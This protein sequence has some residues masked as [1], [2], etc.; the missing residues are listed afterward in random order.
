MRFLW[1]GLLWVSLGAGWAGAKE[2]IERIVIPP[3]AGEALWATAEDL[4]EVVGLR[5]G[6]RPEIV[7]SRWRFP[8]NALY[9]GDTPVNAL[10][11]RL[12]DELSFHGAAVRRGRNGRV[13]IR[14]RSEE[15]LLHGAYTFADREWGARWFLPHDDQVFLV[16]PEPG[17]QVARG[18]R[19]LV[20]PHF[21]HRNL[22]NLRAKTD[23][24]SRRN[25]LS[26]LYEMN[27]ALAHV[28]PPELFD[29]RPELFSTIDG[30]RERP[31][32]S[33]DFDPNPHLAL[34]EA[35]EHAAEV[36]LEYFESNPEAESFSLG[37]ND[38][39]LFDDTELT[40][41]IVEPLQY[42]RGLP[43]HS[44]LVFLFMNR[45]AEL[46]FDQ[47]GAW[48]TPSG[49]PR[50]LSALAY[51]WAEAVPSFPLHGR[52]M[53]ILTADRAQWHDPVFRAEDEALIAAWGRSG[54]ETIATWDYTFGSPYP[55]P[56]QIV[57]PIVASIRQ[58]AASGSRVYFSQFGYRFAYDGAK[59]YLTAQLLWD[60]AADPER[61]LTEFYQGVFGPAATTMRAF[62]EGFEAERNRR[63]G[64]ANWIKFY[65]DEAS[66]E[67]FPLSFLLEKRD[68]LERAAAEA[69]EE[70]AVGDRVAEVQRDFAFTVDYARFQQSRRQLFFALSANHGAE[71][72]LEALGEYLSHR[73]HVLGVYHAHPTLRTI[74]V[75]GQSDPTG[76][77]IGALAERMTEEGQ[78]ARLLRLVPE[79]ATVVEAVRRLQADPA[80]YDLVPATAN[81]FLLHEEEAAGARFLFPPEMPRVE[82]WQFVLRPAERTMIGGLVPHFGFGLVFQDVD[83]AMVLTSGWV[84]LDGVYLLEGNF[85]FRGSPDNRTVVE[86]TWLDDTGKRL[87]RDRPVKFPVEWDD[88]AP[89]DGR[90]FT[91]RIPL[92]PPEGAAQVTVGVA[93]SRQYPGDVLEIRRLG[94]SKIVPLAR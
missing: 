3:G 9:L 63:E 35:A 23:A 21:W 85:R 62:Y 84:E 92:I 34:P 13:F 68:L 79:W 20:E 76:A 81:P 58:L 75:A 60:P 82:G 88:S 86:L 30:R 67:L 19:E 57:E 31:Y 64:A 93:I 43:N 69:K 32:K 49:R 5:D 54:V 70:S 6:K 16:A 45:V 55:Y 50:Y 10:S 91:C 4:A 77:A 66:I 52:V 14:A 94:L 47:G 41:G 24:F 27:H 42:F 44:D 2:G 15:A 87:R 61:L 28:F 12:P 74:D 48:S 78:W 89:S 11:L 18:E 37:I 25:R 56:R 51:Y 26:R 17:E 46:V 59:A 22:H 90:T 72:L 38:N 29:R 39:I 73:H 8:K 33:H 36:V 1:I 83:S 53:P 40:R 80:A 7:Q 65:L 71:P